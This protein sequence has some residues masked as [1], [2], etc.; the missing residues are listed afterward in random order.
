MLLII[1]P[2]C[3]N[4][5]HKCVKEEEK[6]TDNS[7]RAAASLPAAARLCRGRVCCLYGPQCREHALD[8]PT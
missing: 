2:Q 3:A 7:S 8:L 4:E 5:A 6:T 1:E